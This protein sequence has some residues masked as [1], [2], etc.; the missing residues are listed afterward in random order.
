MEQSTVTPPT[1]GE[2]KYIRD[3][4]V[5][6][7]EERDTLVRHARFV[8]FESGDQMTSADDAAIRRASQHVA[9]MVRL[10]DQLGW[11]EE[12]PHD[13]ENFLLLD[14]LLPIEQ[15][16][17][18]VDSRFRVTE[19]EAINDSVR[20]LSE[21]LESALRRHAETFRLLHRM[22]AR[23]DFLRDLSGTR[24]V[25]EIAAPIDEDDAAAARRDA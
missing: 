9:V 10:L 1:S 19:E 21:D 13:S 22:N 16:R 17:V 24:E 12:R 7:A 3:R 5:V 2:A 20:G 4:F 15:I 25:G 14:E 11:S 23:A 6:T 18:W 8:I